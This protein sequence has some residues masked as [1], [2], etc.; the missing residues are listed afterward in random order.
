MDTS[1][2]P[3]HRAELQ[4]IALIPRQEWL[5]GSR[6]CFDIVPLG[7]LAHDN[8][9]QAPGGQYP[10]GGGASLS[11]MA[12]LRLLIVA[13]AVLMNKNGRKPWISAATDAQNNVQAY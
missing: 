8:P 5:S 11:D 6:R 13:L 7:R 4:A 3:G 1:L 10:S 12:E 2:S 9:F